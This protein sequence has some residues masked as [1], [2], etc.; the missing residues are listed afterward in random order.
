M[1]RRSQHPSVVAR[2]G[3]C[4]TGRVR[5]LAYLP[6]ALR[7]GLGLGGSTRWRGSTHSWVE[8]LLW[9]VRVSEFTRPL[10]YALDYG[11]LCWISSQVRDRLASV[12]GSDVVIQL[13]H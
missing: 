7:R 1:A 10:D 12:W 6:G 8:P 11:P 5:V 13:G 4:V 3:R 9:D 2:S